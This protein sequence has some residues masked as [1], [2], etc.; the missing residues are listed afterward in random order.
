MNALLQ[1][2]DDIY[3][4]LLSEV[5]LQNVNVAKLRVLQLSS[6]VENERVWLK[7]RN[8]KSGVG[9][10][11]GM[12]SLEH[13][14][15]NVQGP[16]RKMLIP[17]STFEQ[18]SINALASTGTGLEA[19]VVLDYHDALIHQTQLEGL[20]IVFCEAHIPNLEAKGGIIR[21]DSVYVCE[22]PRTPIPKV[23]TPAISSPALTVTL[24]NHA[25]HP[26]AAIYY[27]TDGTCPGRNPVSG[28]A[29]GTSTAYTVPFLVTSGAAVRWVAYQAGYA[30][31]DVGHGIIT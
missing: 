31:S 11:V 30:G 1:F 6:E 3:T 5:L 14:V 12:P 18:P 24:T 25:T 7:A 4:R 28:A 13:N 16:E 23:I 9:I 29:L 10:V 8:G 17:V 26:A 20:G 2:Q 15:P 19:E 21:Y 27:T 22:A